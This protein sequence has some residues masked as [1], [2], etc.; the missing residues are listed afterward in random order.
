MEGLRIKS[1]NRA[2]TIG[3]AAFRQ[4]GKNP[5]IGSLLVL[6]SRA[7]ATSLE[8]VVSKERDKFQRRDEESDHGEQLGFPRLKE[9]AKRFKG[10]CWDGGRNNIIAI[11]LGDVPTAVGFH[12]INGISSSGKYSDICRMFVC[13]GLVAAKVLLK[14]LGLPEKERIGRG[15]KIKW[16]GEALLRKWN[17]SGEEGCVE[18]VGVRYNDAGDVADPTITREALIWILWEYR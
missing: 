10:S 12:D 1:I 2:S 11:K 18:L 16:P 4:E 14:V 7:I 8:F 9:G 5:S 3:K 15:I 13:K 6:N 17:H